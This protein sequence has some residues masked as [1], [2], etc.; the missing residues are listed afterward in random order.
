MSQEKIQPRPYRAIL[1][2]S[3]NG[4]FNDLE[5]HADAQPIPVLVI[6][7]LDAPLYF[8]NANVARAQILTQTTTDPNPHAI[9][10]DL[11][12]SADLD[13]GTADMLRDL[14]SDLCANQID[15]HFAQ[16]R[17]SVRDRMVRTGLLEHVGEDHFYAS[18]ATAV[19]TF[20]ARPAP[21][22][23]EPKPTLAAPSTT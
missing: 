5:R 14:Y 9:L 10:L 15:L 20:Q 19:A 21:A 1:G 16:V 3:P 12:A 18:L 17:G 8:F 22:A 2:K 11:A 6:L 4:E 23:V 13:I 7:R